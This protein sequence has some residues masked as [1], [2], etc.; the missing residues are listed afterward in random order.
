MKKFILVTMILTLLV[1]C[2]TTRC[3][4]PSTMPSDPLMLPVE[5]INGTVS[6]KDLDNLIENYMR[7]WAHIIII[8][9]KCGGGSEFKASTA[10][11]K[12]HVLNIMKLN[13]NGANI[14][15]VNDYVTYL[16]K[17]KTCK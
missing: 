2:A 14:H 17:N 9:D 6:G 13:K 11:I 8:K 10:V 12:Q 5:V 3:K 16:N 1:G 4:F 7:L 15:T